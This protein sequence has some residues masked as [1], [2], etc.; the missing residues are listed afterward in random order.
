MII[1]KNVNIYKLRD[2]FRTKY[3]HNIKYIDDPMFNL[4]MKYD[5]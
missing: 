1:D 2:L 5:N 3:I 4:G